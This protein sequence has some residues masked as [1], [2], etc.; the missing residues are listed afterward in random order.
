MVRVKRDLLRRSSIGAIFTR[1]S[2]ST[3]SLGSNETYGVDGTFAFYDNVRVD[4][5]W[6]KTR[7]RGFEDDVSYRA[8]F[9][10]AADRYGLQVER[11]VVGT[12]FNPGVGFLRRDD[13]ERS[14]GSFRFSPRPRSIAAIRKVSWEG[15]I[16]YIT[17]RDGVLE[18]R[19][20]RGRFGI[21]FENSDNYDISYTRNYEF[22]KQPFPIAPGVTIPIGGYSFQDVRTSYSFGPQRRL[23]GRLSA[24]HGSFFSGNRTNGYAVSSRQPRADLVTVRGVGPVHAG[25]RPASTIDLSGSLPSLRHLQGFLRLQP[26][27]QCSAYLLTFADPVPLLDLLEAGAIARQ[28]RSPRVDDVLRQLP[29]IRLKTNTYW[30]LLERLL[31]QLPRFIYFDQ[32]SSLCLTLSTAFD[33]THDAAVRW[34]NLR[35]ARIVSTRVEQIDAVPP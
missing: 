32:R 15:R 27:R 16:D 14:F 9:D 6:A 31:E 20:A 13:F 23:A 3:Q 25:Q 1:R 21:E 28:G 35:D 10:Y 30:L 8:Q 33:P 19:E 22:L 34:Q 7:T 26:A 11:L 12:D 4:T 29:T 18:I 24:Q 5:Y 17:A 2:L